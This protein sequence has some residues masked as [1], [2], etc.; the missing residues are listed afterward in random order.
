MGITKGGKEYYYIVRVGEISDTFDT[1]YRWCIT[2]LSISVE[3][4]TN[5]FNNG[6]LDYLFLEKS[7][8]LYFWLVW[9]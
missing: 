1:R 5:K 6:G 7:D 4:W 3:R 2:N 8:A 9:S